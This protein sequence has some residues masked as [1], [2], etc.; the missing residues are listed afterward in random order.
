[1]V[2]VPVA[3]CDIQPTSDSAPNIVAAATG[4]KQSPLTRL[5]FVA[6]AESPFLQPPLFQR[7][8]LLA[9]SAEGLDQC[10]GIVPLNGAA[11]LP[12]LRLE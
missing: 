7:F 9:G 5:N 6:N 3:R 10:F 11:Q 4:G 8:P 1:M 12:Q 2:H